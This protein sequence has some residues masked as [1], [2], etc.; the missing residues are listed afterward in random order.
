MHLER[1]PVTVAAQTVQ[2]SA[3]PHAYAKWEGLAADLGWYDQAHF[4]NDFKA[5]LGCTPG[6]YAARHGLP[7]E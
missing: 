6:Q 1:L 7:A 5:M 3:F 2:R 4:S